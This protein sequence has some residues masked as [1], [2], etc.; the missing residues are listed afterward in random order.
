MHALKVL[1]IK[2]NLKPETLNPG[3]LCK[4]CKGFSRGMLKTSISCI[5]FLFREYSAF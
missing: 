1:F 5:P 4:A 2:R 3:L